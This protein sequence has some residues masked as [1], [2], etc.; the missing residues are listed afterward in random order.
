MAGCAIAAAAPAAAATFTLP[1][2][3]A[4]AYDTN[5][6]LQGAR[7]ALRALDEGVAQANAGWRPSINASGSYGIQHANVDGFANPT[8]SHPTIGQVT[9][10]EPIFRGGRT[11]AQIRRAI[12]DVRAGRAGLLAAEQSVLLE[13]VTAYMDVV[14]DLDT[15]RFNRENVSTLQ[16]QLEA[17]RTQFNAGAVTRTDAAQAEA[18]FARAEADLASADEQLAAS[19]A[20]FE[21]VIGR[22]PETLDT[23]PRLPH[24]PQSRESAH[25]IAEGHPDVMQAKASARSADYAVDD[26]AGA[27]L[28]QIAVSGQYQYLKDA[29]GTNI[30]GTKSPQGILSVTGQVTVPIYQGG[31]D[32]ATVRRA[33]ELRT[34]AQMSVTTTERRVRRE[35]DSAWQS[36]ISALAAIRANEAQVKADQGAVAGVTE[37]QKAGERSVLDI[38]NAR[39][40][41]LGSQVAL[42]A[43]R[44]DYVV[45][46]YRLV[47]AT[48]QLSARFLA[49]KVRYYDPTAHY[50]ESADAWF[51][52]GD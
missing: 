16:R 30:F 49:L 22:P 20:A 13:A 34:Q 36:L 4:I 48:G 17:V 6:Q 43:A 9:V 10:S 45:S 33:K 15:L 25:I 47:S 14:R 46:A 51:G 19:R 41:L 5:P 7:A 32:E 50:E 29:A 24:L 44:R 11:T 28:P 12:S 39:Q 18:R 52:I 8:N 26:A 2:A 27:L 35:V 3:L 40:E 42:A 23:A 38:L 37:E 31:G 1:E 21:D